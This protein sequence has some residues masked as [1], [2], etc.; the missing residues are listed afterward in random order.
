MV[1]AS[2]GDNDRLQHEKEEGSVG[3]SG[4]HG[5]LGG[6][7]GSRKKMG[8]DRDGRRQLARGGVVIVSRVGE[9]TVVADRGGK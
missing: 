7:L 1:M 4:G 9:A 6:G 2:W 3:Y 8:I 5:K